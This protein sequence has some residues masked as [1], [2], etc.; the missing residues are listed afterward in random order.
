MRLFLVAIVA[1]TTVSFTAPWELYVETQ[2]VPQRITAAC[3]PNVQHAEIIDV[4]LGHAARAAIDCL[5]HHAVVTVDDGGRFRPDAPVTASELGDW[6]ITVGELAGLEVTRPS[7]GDDGMTRGEVAEVL[8]GV[9][10]TAD[11][12]PSP[13]RLPFADVSSADAAGPAIIAGLVPV[14]SRDLVGVHDPADRALAATAVARTLA[15]LA[16]AGD[17]GLD[18][19]SE[20]RWGDI[21]PGRLP[22]L[23]LP[24]AEDATYSIDSPLLDDG[25]HVRFNPCRPVEVVANLE[26]APAFA[27]DAI[28]EALEALTAAMGTRWELV[29]ETDEQLEHGLSRRLVTDRDRPGGR[30][31]VLIT[32][33]Q[34]WPS[35]WTGHDALAFAEA[36]MIDGVEIVTGSVR[37][38][39]EEDWRYDQLVWVLMHELGHVAGLGHADDPGQVMHGTVAEFPEDPSFRGGDLAGLA[40]LG[41]GAG[42]Y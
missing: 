23:P 2:P 9:I 16:D 18:A 21:P 37:V 41:R 7:G 30:Q 6:L 25:T 31:P 39:P 20:P 12:S 3:P 40:R 26:H 1:L 29:G 38:N 14:A 32:W 22:H 17:L 4:P 35:S 10:A 13:V 27:H 15:H 24:E 34:D 5:A 28:L 11:A 8:A 42:C 36:K 19:P 33:P